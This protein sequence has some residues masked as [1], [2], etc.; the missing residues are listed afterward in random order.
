MSTSWRH[1]ALNAV[2]YHLDGFDHQMPLDT[3]L[4]INNSCPLSPLRKKTKWILL[5]KKGHNFKFFDSQWNMVSNIKNKKLLCNF[6]LGIQTMYMIAWWCCKVAW[7]NIGDCRV[8][9]NYYT[10]FSTG[11]FTY[12]FFLNVGNKEIS[13]L[14]F[15]YIMFR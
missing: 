1:R 4:S 11:W 5:N 2:G 15:L 13:K 8:G 3:I 12:I 14:K 9:L 6:V 10:P 7:W